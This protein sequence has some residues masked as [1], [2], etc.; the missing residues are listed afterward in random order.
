MRALIIDDSR[1]MRS[2]LRRVI[3]PLGFEAA[4]AADGQDALDQIAAGPVPE[5]CL[6]DW[7]MPVMDG[8][9][10][11]TR[12]RERPEWRDVT[13]MMVT[14]ESEHSQ[15]VRALAAGAHEYVVKPFTPEAIREKLALLG[16]L[17]E[18]VRA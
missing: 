12:M 15:V 17:S 1:V 3:E 8:Y 4:E 7:N 13:L 9:S 2:I 16:L 5:L 6:V 18:G 10:F 11:I 14:T